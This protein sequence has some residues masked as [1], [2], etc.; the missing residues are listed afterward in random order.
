MSVRD[1]DVLGMPKYHREYQRMSTNPL[2]L[3][4]PQFNTHIASQHR[5]RCRG[6]AVVD[7]LNWGKETGLAYAPHRNQRVAFDHHDSMHPTSLPRYAGEGWSEGQ[8]PSSG[9]K[10]VQ[11]GFR[12]TGYEFCQPQHMNTF[13]TNGWPSQA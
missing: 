11:Q 2:K 4:G 13:L 1:R 7:W 6:E 9:L 3:H 8:D 10:D 5:I 12:P